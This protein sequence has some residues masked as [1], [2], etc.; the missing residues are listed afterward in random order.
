MVKTY[1]KDYTNTYLIR[2]AEITVT[3]PA[4]FNSETNEIMADKQLDDAAVEMAYRKY[5]QQF[6]VVSPLDI[7]RLRKKWQLTQQQ[8]ADVIGWSPSTVAL[9]E[10]GELPTTANNRLLKVLMADDHTMEL[11][12]QASQRK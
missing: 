5:R 12:I 11:F 8:F 9:Y 3:A 1:I 10:V 6:S 2:G 4:R 7:K